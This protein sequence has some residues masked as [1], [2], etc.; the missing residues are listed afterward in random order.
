[1]DVG[2]PQTPDRPL[3]IVYVDG[4]GDVIG[5]YRLWTSGQGDASEVSTTFSGDFFDFA[6]TIEA[7]AT[8]IAT[9]P[10][11][12]TLLGQPPITKIEH[13]PIPWQSAGG[14]RYHLGQLWYGMFLVLKAI[15]FRA[16]LL[17][18]VEGTHWFLLWPARLCGIK[19]VP[20]LHCTFWPRNHRRGGRLTKLIWALNGRFWRSA[21][22]AT[23]CISP[24]AE[25]QVMEVSHH[26]PRGPLIPVRSQYHRPFFAAIPPPPENRTPFRVLFAGRIETS[27]GVFDLLELARRLHAKRPGEFVFELCGTGTALADLTT[28]AADLPDQFILRG[29]CSAA[30]MQDAYARSHA[31]I[32]PTTPNFAEGMN[33]VAIEGVLAGRP[34]VTTELSHTTDVLGAAI[35]EVRPQDLDDYERALLHLK[36]DPAFYS[37]TAAATRSVTEPFLDGNLSYRNALLTMATTLFPSRIPSTA[38]AL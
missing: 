26:K 28:A 29:R 18:V 2:M 23:L 13:L 27:K 33:R 12:A 1:M 9:N 30:Q 38:A 31:V 32:V 35:V 11:R 21:V 4:P 6:R 5:T 22:A 19:I 7:A 17:L 14:L 36:D 24:E 25:R 16:D 34:V 37:A 15:T 8:V 3:R 20:M 10:H